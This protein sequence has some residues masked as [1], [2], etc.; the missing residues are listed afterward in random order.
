MAR[1]RVERLWIGGG[2][3][4]AVLVAAVGWMVVVHPKLSDASSL[5]SQTDDAQAANI[6][7][8]TKIDKLERDKANMGALQKS[9]ADAQAALPSDSGLAAFTRQIGAQ[10]A[11]AHVTVTSITASTP[12]PVG[13]AAPAAPAATTDTS[14][15]TAA[16]S[17]PPAPAASGAAATPHGAYVIPL[18]VS[19][20]GNADAEVRFLTALQHGSRAVLVTSAQLA[21]AGAGSSGDTALTIQLQA[22][23]VPQAAP[24]TSSAGS[25][26]GS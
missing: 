9:L 12:T 14:T 15:A 4:A 3:V 24:A 10:A 22:F 25:T 5:R 26:G 7:L 11:A 17:S 1:E 6:V 19:V 16:P 23:A 13:G 20:S 18:T 8:Q 21:A 2:T